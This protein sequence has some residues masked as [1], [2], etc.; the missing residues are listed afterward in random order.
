MPRG[1]TALTAQSF[2]SSF[3]SPASDDPAPEPV[4]ERLLR[5]TVALKYL[6]VSARISCGVVGVRVRG[7]V[8]TGWRERLRSQC[9]LYE[10]CAD[11]STAGCSRAQKPARGDV[12]P[13]PRHPTFS[14]LRRF[15]VLSSSSSCGSER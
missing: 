12:S 5:A 14:R 15:R 6:T 3:P 2:L 7:E 4:T 1:P 10:R 8:G 9:W 11:G 13:E